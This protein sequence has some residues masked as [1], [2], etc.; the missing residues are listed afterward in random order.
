MNECIDV[1]TVESGDYTIQLI[2]DKVKMWLTD[3]P[4]TPINMEINTLQKMLQSAT[5]LRRRKT[6]I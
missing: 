4:E 6:D 1:I 3:T 5:M 2:G